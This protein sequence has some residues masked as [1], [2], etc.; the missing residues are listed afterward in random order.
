[1]EVNLKRDKLIFTGGTSH[2]FKEQ[3]LEV[4]PKATFVE[5]PFFA[6]AKGMYARMMSDYREFL[7]NWKVKIANE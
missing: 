4:F 2:R 3:V 5:D 6:N 7:E 1:M